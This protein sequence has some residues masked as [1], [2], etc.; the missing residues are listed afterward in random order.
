MADETAATMVSGHERVVMVTSSYP[1]FA[2]DTVG[3]F[4]EPIA[5]GLAAR[6]HDVHIVLPWHP[7]LARG[8]RENG[9]HFH[10]FRY[11]PTRALHVFGYAG[12]LEA[13]ERLR[14]SAVAVTPMAL[15]SAWASAARVARRIQATIVHAHWVV[16]GGAIAA[17]AARGV[18]HVISLHGSDV[19][20]AERYGFARRAARFA[21][22]RAAWVTSC[23]DDL[24]GRALGLGADP[25]RT[26]TIPYGVDA[27]R[28]HPDA[29][30]RAAYRERL[31]LGEATAIVFTAGRFVRKKGFEYLIEAFGLAPL[32]SKRATLVVAG[33]GDLE[34]DLR[35]R[36]DRIGSSR[37]RFIGL[38]AQDEIAGYLAAADIAAVPSVRDEAGNV[39][40]LPNVVM[41]ALAS[42]TPLVAT[43]AGGIPSVVEHGRTGMLVA[44][45]SPAEL[46]SAISRLID[47]SGLRAR[48]GA[49][50]RQQV[51]SRHAWV[52][53]A[54]RFE[55]VYRSAH[56]CL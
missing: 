19:Y 44:E 39:D 23:S 30:R 24:R 50:A 14:P 18:P 43:T 15:L 2:G 12:A 40:G 46:A 32:A 16:P 36:A 4:L 38:I 29:T 6:G 41:E 55:E 5:K 22:R 26:T 1:R 27:D 37:I 31:G 28:F 8:A 47:D 53:V 33:G 9:L 52:D 56:A 35:T 3:T 20:V 45:R 25:H 10:P 54:R 49:A 34:R 42:A 7:R 11:A 13:D 21:L 17:L 48:L 51:V